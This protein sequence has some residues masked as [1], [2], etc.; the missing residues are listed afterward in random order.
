MSSRGEDEW[1]PRPAVSGPVT[2]QDFTG[3][4]GEPPSEGREVGERWET[5]LG[6]LVWDG[7]KWT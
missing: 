2:W 7:E 5:R 6:V 4:G 1:L 3:K